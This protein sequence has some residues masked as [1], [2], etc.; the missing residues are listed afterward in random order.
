MNFQVN[1][2]MTIS[3]MQVLVQFGEPRKVYTV[4][5]KNSCCHCLSSSSGLG[6]G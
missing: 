3:E 6:H 1:L 2:L 5:V 4:L